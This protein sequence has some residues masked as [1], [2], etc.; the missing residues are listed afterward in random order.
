VRK[1][2]HCGSNRDHTPRPLFAYARRYVQSFT[3]AETPRCDHSVIACLRHI[4]I[5]VS[6]FAHIPFVVNHTF[7]AA[8]TERLQQ[9]YLRLFHY[10]ARNGKVRKGDKKE[11][12]IEKASEEEGKKACPV[13][14]TMRSVINQTTAQIGGK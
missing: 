2:S 3:S 14:A 5:W 7:N 9:Q 6:F 12:K 8:P 10:K 4:Y 1:A 13:L 11:F